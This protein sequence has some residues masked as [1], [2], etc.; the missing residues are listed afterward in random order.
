MGKLIAEV[1]VGTFVVLAVAEAMQLISWLS[2]LLR[3]P[4]DK[5]F[6]AGGAICYVVYRTARF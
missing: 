3:E 2:V 4:V 5:T 1:L 6:I